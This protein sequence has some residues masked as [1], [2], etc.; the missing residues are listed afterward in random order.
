MAKKKEKSAKPEKL[1]MV[2]TNKDIPK[3]DVKPKK[4]GIIEVKD[5]PKQPQ[6]KVAKSYKPGENTVIM[7]GDFKPRKFKDCR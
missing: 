6:P 3:A 1:K 5:I 4:L 2:T 7:T